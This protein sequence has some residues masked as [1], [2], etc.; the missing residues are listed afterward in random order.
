MPDLQCPRSCDDTRLACPRKPLQVVRYPGSGN[1]DGPVGTDKACWYFG[2][3]KR[4][5][6]PNGGPGPPP[7]HIRP[8]GRVVSN[9]WELRQSP[10]WVVSTPR[11]LPCPQPG[12]GV[13]T[14]V[15]SMPD[16]IPAC[17]ITTTTLYRRTR[18]VPAH[19]R[20]PGLR[21]SP[22]IEEHVRLTIS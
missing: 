9:P 21:P 15:H 4:Q 20:C 6:T 1:S 10:G 14:G 19:I 2:L 8:T 12:P 17:S 11:E 13:T 3:E 16:P 18:V 22:Y 5:A 7:H